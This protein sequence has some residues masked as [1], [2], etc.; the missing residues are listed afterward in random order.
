MKQVAEKIKRDYQEA[1]KINLETA[2]LLASNRVLDHFEKEYSRLIL[3]GNT[4]Y[5]DN[6]EL[7]QF[8]E[9]FITPEFSE[10][11]HY[12]LLCAMSFMESSDLTNKVKD[13]IRAIHFTD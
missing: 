5:S 10:Q 1:L 12:N 9:F 2:V 7:A 11:V 13:K 8:L 4:E 6:V 3:G